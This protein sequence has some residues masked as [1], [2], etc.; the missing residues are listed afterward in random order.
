M[1]I[2]W[3]DLLASVITP[4]VFLTII[5]ENVFTL[6]DWKIQPTWLMWSQIPKSKNS[7]NLQVYSSHFNMSSWNIK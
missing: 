7:L 5:S 2:Y 4:Q 1:V 6:A 3:T